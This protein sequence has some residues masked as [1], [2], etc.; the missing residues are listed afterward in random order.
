MFLL[1]S[2][3]VGGVGRGMVGGGPGDGRRMSL[4]V[5]YFLPTACPIFPWEISADGSNWGV[6]GVGDGR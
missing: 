1:V 4:E 6:Q 3:V 5:L 2:C